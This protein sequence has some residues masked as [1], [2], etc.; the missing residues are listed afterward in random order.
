[1]LAEWNLLRDDENEIKNAFE[2]ASLY[3]QSGIKHEI[4]FYNL[5]IDLNF[6]SAIKSA[7]KTEHFIKTQLKKVFNEEIHLEDIFQKQFRKTKI[8]FSPENK[9]T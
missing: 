2:F 8:K 6:K 5:F 9:V 1:M 4:A 7:L 3:K